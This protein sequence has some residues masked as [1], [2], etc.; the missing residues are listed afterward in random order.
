[1]ILALLLAGA[2]TTTAVDAERA[3]AAAAIRDG[4][5]T[6]FRAYATA[7]AVMFAAKPVRTQ[8]FLRD[9][10]DPK[11][12]L[13]WSPTASYVSCDGKLAINTGEWT[14][15]TGGQGYFTTVWQR[16]GDGSWK[17]LMDH[18]DDLATP[19]LP[20]EPTV[21]QAACRGKPKPYV[22]PVSAQQGGGGSP[23]G[24]LQWRWT[25]DEHGAR[26]VTAMLWN[27]DGWDTVLSDAVAAPAPAAKPQ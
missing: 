2:G 7:D 14:H 4:Q 20:A 10:K 19:R 15:P 8:E 3:F 1:M 11:D 24:S 26:T 9:R 6:A 18:G 21:R 25:V 22:V 27:G 17:W 5:W 16:Q 13:H 12:A 23:D